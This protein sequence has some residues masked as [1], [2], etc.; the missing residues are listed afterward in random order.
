MPYESL[1]Q[2]SNPATSRLPAVR[3]TAGDGDLAEDI[4]IPI[5]NS[6]PSATT[7]APLNP[8][9]DGEAEFEQRFAAAIAQVGDPARDLRTFA[10]ALFAMPPRQGEV[11]GSPAAQVR[12][13]GAALALY[14]PEW[15]TPGA[16]EFLFAGTIGAYEDGK[17]AFDPALVRV[18]QDLAAVGSIDVQ[19]RDIILLRHAPETLQALRATL[20]D[21]YLTKTLAIA[22]WRAGQIT[23]GAFG[24]SNISG[25]MI[26][27]RMQQFGQ[28]GCQEIQRMAD[29]SVWEVPVTLGVLAS[30]RYSDGPDDLSAGLTPEYDLRE[31]STQMVVLGTAARLVSS[32][33][34]HAP[35]ALP[36][37]VAPNDRCGSTGL[38]TSIAELFQSSEDPTVPKIVLVETHMRVLAQSAAIAADLAGTLAAVRVLAPVN[39]EHPNVVRMEPYQVDGEPDDLP[40][41]GG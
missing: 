35:R 5:P 22:Q 16:A 33:D 4:P 14:R 18:S 6:E 29:F 27:R 23:A 38:Y 15:Q 20:L 10:R 1:G 31:E 30:C 36:Q 26:E 9:G 32:F 13:P 24:R 7:I 3:R 2:F 17:F 11:L 19:E 40:G 8:P 25:Q 21:A 28:A 12:D 41:R 34:P 37:A 39:L